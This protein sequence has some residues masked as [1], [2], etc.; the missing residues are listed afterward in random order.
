MILKTILEETRF[1]IS[2]CF[3]N[4]IESMPEVNK[5]CGSDVE[6]ENVK[7][8]MYVLHVQLYSERMDK[9]TVVFFIQ[10]N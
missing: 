7:K 4:S 1:S 3:V 6:T 5:L 2:S 9:V 8:M 10:S